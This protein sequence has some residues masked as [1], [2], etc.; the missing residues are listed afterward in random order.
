MIQVFKDPESTRWYNGQYKG[1]QAQRSPWQQRYLSPL[2]PTSA[3]GL[4]RAWGASCEYSE[5]GNLSMQYHCGSWVST[6]TVWY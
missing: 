5:A 3:V 1:E 2:A 4:S 6:G